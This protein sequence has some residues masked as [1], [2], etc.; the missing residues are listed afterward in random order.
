MTLNATYLGLNEGQCLPIA[1]ITALEFFDTNGIKS[2]Y[3]LSRDYGLALGNLGYERLVKCLN[4]F[5]SKL[6]LNKSN[7]GSKKTLLSVY[8][9][10]KKPGP[11]L[12]ETLLKKRQKP[13]D[14]AKQ[15]QSVTFSKITNMVL[16]SNVTFGEIV[17]L[18]S[19][20]GFNTRI[21][22]FLF[23][24]YNNI[25]GLNT[26]VSHF[27]NTVDRRCTICKINQSNI[28]IGTNRN[29]VPVPVNPVP[30]PTADE[31]FKHMFLDCPTV[32]KLHDQF[33]NKYFTGLMFASE[34]ER[35]YFFFYGTVPGHRNYNIFV[36]ATVLI[37]QYQIWQTKLK[38]RL[39]SFESLTIPLMENLLGFFCNNKEA[40]K[41]SLEFNFP[42]CRSV[43]RLPA[44]DLAVR[45]PQLE[46]AAAAANQPAPQVAPPAPGIPPAPPWRH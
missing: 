6:K 24:F 1:N 36:H 34:I 23:K 31:S 46:R 4:H 30:T 2:A 35:A 39:L 10:L 5:V 41:K 44:Q 40:R 17:S 16:P 13:F 14:L 3:D 37:F 32:K 18:W 19:K 27:N 38:K 9:K 15:P 42:L 20:N 8:G 26:R 25:L 28:S 22:T 45:A 33:L 7:D 21:K 29:T 12:R 11:K 43:N